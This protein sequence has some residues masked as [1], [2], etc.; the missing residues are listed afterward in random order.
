MYW[1]TNSHSCLC[2]NIL[3]EVAVTAAQYFIDGMFYILTLI[4]HFTSNQKPNWNLLQSTDSLP[5]SSAPD[6]QSHD[7][8]S[9]S[10]TFKCQLHPELQTHKNHKESIPC[11]SRQLGPV[12][13]VTDILPTQFN[14]GFPLAPLACLSLSRMCIEWFNTLLP[15]CVHL[16]PPAASEEVALSSVNGHMWSP[17]IARPVPTDCELVLFSPLLH[18]GSFFFFHFFYGTGSTSVLWWPWPVGSR[19]KWARAH[20]SS[21]SLSRAVLFPFPRRWTGPKMAS[22]S[23]LSQGALYYLIRDRVRSCLLYVSRSGYVHV[24]IRYVPY[25]FGW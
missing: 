17:F 23:S 14:H 15:S 7:L 4:E 1:S 18:S 11:M 12:V 5:A 21:S 9:Y 25:H 19:S 24:V 3:Y 6:H 22:S 10:P 2:K 16:P 20:R 8:P 13:A